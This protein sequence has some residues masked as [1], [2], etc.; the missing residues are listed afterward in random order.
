MS[1]LN[2]ADFEAQAAFRYALRQFLGFS[3]KTTRALGTTPQT[4][5]ALLAIHGYPGR[6]RITIGELAE[7]LQIRHHS[8]VGMADRL[9][10]QGLVM[11]RAGE[12]DRRQVFVQLTPQGKELLE[13]LVLAHR[14]ELRHLWPQLEQPVQRLTNNDV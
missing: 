10:K 1:E 12:E 5:Q 14:E 9:E 6:E 8:A 7:R 13:K 2:K 4:Y 3:E 11:R